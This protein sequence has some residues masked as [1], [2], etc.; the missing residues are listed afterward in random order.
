VSETVKVEHPESVAAVAV[1]MHAAGHCYR[2]IGQKFGM[3]ASET[4]KVCKASKPEPQ[5][6]PKP[7]I[8]VRLR[9][10][11]RESLD[12]MFS[13]AGGAAQNQN[14]SQFAA[15]LLEGVVV[16]FRRLKLSAKSEAWERASRA[17]SRRKPKSH[18]RIT[19]NLR[20]ATRVIGNDVHRQKV[21]A[22]QRDGMRAMAANPEF[23]GPHLVTLLS[24]RFEC[25]RTTARRIRAGATNA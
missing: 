18:D 11:I 5:P 16:D 17:E 15:E 25:S 10:E 13:I 9:N 8:V 1:D 22:E 14:V 6:Q 24:Q 3:T 4:S 20:R 19:A 23:S 7:E 12:E 2:E 21:S